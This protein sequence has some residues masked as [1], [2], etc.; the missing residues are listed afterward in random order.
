MSQRDLLGLSNSVS[1]DAVTLESSATY[2]DSATDAIH[3]SVGT[4]PSWF[5]STDSERSKS[6]WR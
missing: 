1:S 6:S 4:T 5:F 3:G 2:E